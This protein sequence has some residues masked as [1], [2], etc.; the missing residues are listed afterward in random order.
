MVVLVGG[1]IALL[2]YFHGTK[3]GDRWWVITLSVA[4]FLLVLVVAGI[5]ADLDSKEEERAKID[6]QRA[7]DQVT[8]T[9]DQLRNAYREPLRSDVEAEGLEPDRSD[10]G[11]GDG[12]FGTDGAGTTGG[13]EEGADAQE[14]FV[15]STQPGPSNPAE[16]VVFWET[17]YKRIVAYHGEAHNQLRSSYRLAQMSAVAGFLLVAAIGISAAF[18]PSKTQSIAAAAVGAVGAALAAYIGRTFNSTYTKA[19]QRSSAFFHEPVV[20]ARL[21]AGE[22]LLSEYGDA[23]S[24]A[25]AQ[26]LTT[27]IGAAV[28]FES[29]AVPGVE[30]TD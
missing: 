9:A 21:L 27:M 22:R 6:Q 19:L 23:D 25:R 29:G 20:M 3:G 8:T 12:A 18:V 11:G 1:G 5:F 7:L 4:M 13:P 2:V 10:G 28:N 15:H 24:A 14:T 16:F 26:A 17:T 30:V